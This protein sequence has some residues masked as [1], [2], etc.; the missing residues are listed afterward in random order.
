VLSDY[1]DGVIANYGPAILSGSAL[2]ISF[3]SW[4]LYPLGW[5]A[6]V[7]LLIQTWRSKPAAVAAKFFVAGFAFHLILLQ[8]QLSNM[9]WG[10][11]WAVWGYVGL[12]LF[13]SVYW[14]LLGAAWRQVSKALPRIPAWAT[15]PV[16]WFAMETVQARLFTGFGWGALGYAQ[17][18]DLRIV[19]WAA[20][21]GVS[22]VSAILVVVNG[23]AAH[24]FCNRRFRIPI[25]LGG[26]GVIVL[27]HVGGGFMMDTPDYSSTPYAAGIIQPDYPLETKWDREY[28]LNMVENAAEKSRM[29]VDVAGPVDL[30]VW[31]EAHVMGDVYRPGILPTLSSL[32]QDVDTFLYTGAHR[33]N[34][35]TGGSFNSSYLIEP[36]GEIVAQYD[37]IH[38]APFGE[39]V[40]LSQFLPF[41][42]KVV[43]AIGDIES[44]TDQTTLEAN[45]KTLGPL[46]CF[47]VLFAPMAETL[48]DSGAELLVVITN[49]AWFGSSNAIPQ[50]L[51][52]ARL[53][54]IETRLPL[55]HC[56]NTGVSGMFDPW[57]R[58]DDVDLYVGAG[59]PVNR[60]D[61]PQAAKVAQRFAGR[62]P[63]AAPGQRLIPG[64]PVYIPRL[65]FVLACLL[66]CVGLWR[67]YGSSTKTNESP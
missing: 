38:L 53:R 54:A 21:G 58:F 14:S 49:L 61:L 60:P 8:W 41:I 27:S 66:L 23:M 59:G 25:I 5:V 46:I 42:A 55:A 26:L 62:F 17:G 12:C 57:G 56:A 39:Y 9:Y 37:K 44:G 6:L 32:T 65:V 50:E 64:G 30:L 22:L 13:M 18:P 35:E 3:P 33:S 67:G 51:E 19:Q 40:P 45:D 34:P 11:G 52:I 29:L 20:I 36:S 43:P 47:E 10:G 4:H 48:R 24:A 31:P 16:F 28:T 1:K 2:A 7:P 63:V 15:L